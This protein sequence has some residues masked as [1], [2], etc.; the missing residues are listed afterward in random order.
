M[1]GNSMLEEENVIEDVR[2]LFRLAK[3]KRETTDITIKDIGNLF[4]QNNNNNNN[5]NN[6]VQRGIVSSHGERDPL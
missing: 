4:R 1:M 3:L 5:N 6:N 2:N